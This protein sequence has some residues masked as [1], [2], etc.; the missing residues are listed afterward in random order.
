MTP[1]I[2]ELFIPM[3]LFA[4]FGLIMFAFFHFRHKTSSLEQKTLQL[5]IEKGTELTPQMIDRMIRPP[6][7]PTMD[8]R[9]GIILL[10]CGVAIALF[11]L[12]LG[13]KDAARPLLAIAMLPAIVGLAYVMLWKLAARGQSS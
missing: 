1:D 7:S 3:V 8:L 5:A 2:V 12:V 9:R 4:V 6:R 10:A 13:E 11:G